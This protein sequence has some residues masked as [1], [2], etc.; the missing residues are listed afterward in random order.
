ML[1]NRFMA[2]AILATKLYIPQAR[3]D[4][5]TRLRLIDRLNKGLAMGCKLTLIS[6]A[7]GFGKTTM[8]SEWI[9]GCKMPVAWLSLDEGD[10]DPVRFLSY[11]IAALQTIKAGIGEGLLPVLDSN[12]PQVEAI[13]TALLNDVSVI[14]EHFL[15]I[16]DDYHLIDSQAVDQFLAF[17]IG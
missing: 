9:A 8:M 16:L 6:A 10:G 15:L 5:V 2:M 1:Y 13:L 17:F 4:V 12:Q 3:P 11:M 7:A 14:P